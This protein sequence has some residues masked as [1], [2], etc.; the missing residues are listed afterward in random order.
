MKM[1]VAINTL[2]LTKKVEK[3][4]FLKWHL[5]LEF[6]GESSVV[7]RTTKKVELKKSL[8]IFLFKNAQ[9]PYRK[10]K[11][12]IKNNLK[13]IKFSSSSWGGTV[14]S[15]SWLVNEIFFL[16]ILLLSVLDILVKNY[17][18]PLNHDYIRLF[19]G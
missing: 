3:Y 1:K 17:F 15:S 19:L 7:V 11:K 8:F 4:F 12:I 2:N 13:R 18:W 16:A 6:H 10:A 9:K 5:F 14:F